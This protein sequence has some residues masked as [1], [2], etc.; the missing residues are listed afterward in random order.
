MMLCSLIN[1]NDSF[2]ASCH[3]TCCLPQARRAER[4]GRRKITRM[5]SVPNFERAP[6]LARPASFLSIRRPGPRNVLRL[7]SSRLMGQLSPG[8]APWCCF[9]GAI[10]L[11]SEKGLFTREI[12]GGDFLTCSSCRLEDI[13]KIVQV[14]NPERSEGGSRLAAPKRQSFIF[15]ILG[16]LI[17][18]YVYGNLH[19]QYPTFSPSGL[20]SKISSLNS[21]F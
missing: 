6:V 3:L 8:L 11:A 15:R 12:M 16:N 20:T 7:L 10:L 4:E 5:D 18:T 19:D 9:F 21:I 1:K 17:G 2:G 13:T 14:K